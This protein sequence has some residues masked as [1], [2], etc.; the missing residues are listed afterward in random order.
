MGMPSRTVDLVRLIFYIEDTS[1][2]TYYYSC[3]LVGV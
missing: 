3:F 2:S 1:V